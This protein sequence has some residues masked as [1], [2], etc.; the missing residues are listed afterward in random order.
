MLVVAIAALPTGKNQALPTK[1]VSLAVSE[2]DINPASRQ[3]QEAAP[4]DFSWI[5]VDIEAGDNLARIFQRLEL[6]LTDLHNIMDANPQAGA[7]TKIL[8]GQ[9]L[10]FQLDRSGDLSAIRYHYD[11]LRT[12]LVKRAETGFVADW[13]T[14]APDTINVF[15]TAEITAAHPS[16]YAA[17]KSVGLSDYIIMEL[18]QIFQ[19]DISFALDLRNG[20]SFALI[21]EEIYVE[22]ERINEGNIIAARFTNMARTYNAVRYTDLSGS[23]G[24]YTPAGASMRKAFIRD[25][26]HFTHVSSSFNPRRFHPIHKRVMPHRGIDYAA[27]RGTPVVASGDGKV[28][29]RRSNQAAGR[30]IVIQHGEQYTTKYLHLDSFAPGI[31]PGASVKLGQVIGHVGSSG[32]ATA[33]HLHYEFLVGGVH[34]NPRAVKLPQADSIPIDEL[35]RFRAAVS[36]VLAQFEAIVD[37]RHYAAGNKPLIQVTDGGPV[38]QKGG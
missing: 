29:V 2:E 20:D 36:P 15:E 21:Y 17:G 19:W 24:Y 23:S 1:P 22:G 4:P 30:H 8:P 34:R 11:A 38:Q 33:P 13:K 35:A 28:I 10:S 27:K 32:W 6:S 5:H 3:F 31:K 14:A 25:P 9:K 16:L 18:A 26:V 12:L 37:K 7:F